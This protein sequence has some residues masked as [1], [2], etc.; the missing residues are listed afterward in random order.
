MPGLIESFHYS[1]WADLPMEYACLLNTLPH[2]RLDATY[3][4]LNTES[5]GKV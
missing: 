2:Y 3:I 1:I 4:S 5:S